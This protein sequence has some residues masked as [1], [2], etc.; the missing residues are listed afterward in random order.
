MSS[1]SE[2]YRELLDLKEIQRDK[3]LLMGDMQRHLFSSRYTPDPRSKCFH[4]VCVPILVL[5]R[6]MLEYLILCLF[7]E[8]HSENHLFQEVIMVLFHAN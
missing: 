6:G 4:L 7:T 8:D 5:F 3:G 2:E 1:I